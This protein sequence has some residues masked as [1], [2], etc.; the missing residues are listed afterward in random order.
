MSQVSPPTNAPSEEGNT[1]Q[2]RAYKV[3]DA[4]V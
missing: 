1:V 4:T 2:L 3:V